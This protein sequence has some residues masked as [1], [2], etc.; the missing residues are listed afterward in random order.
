MKNEWKIWN[1]VD[2]G[3]VTDAQHEGPVENMEKQLK[4]RWSSQ[5]RF[6]IRWRLV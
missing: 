3:A 6:C 1:G 5:V 4:Q 2:R